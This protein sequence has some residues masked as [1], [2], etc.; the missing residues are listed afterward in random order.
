MRFRRVA[1]VFVATL[2]SVP[3]AG[4]GGEGTSTQCSLTECTVTLQRGVDA[5]VGILGADVRLVDVAGDVVT[6]EVAGSQVQLRVN[7]GVQVAG[8]QVE[9]VELTDSEAV[10]RI[11]QGGEGGG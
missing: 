9:L 6:L 2:L 4:C 3:L 7:E 5:Q 1:G 8:F 10:V 11:S